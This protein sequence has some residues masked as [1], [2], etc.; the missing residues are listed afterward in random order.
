MT[1]ILHRA[2]NDP[3]PRELELL[4]D[5]T[6]H[7]AAGDSISSVLEAVATGFRAVLPFDRMEYS[8]VD[9]DDRTFVVHWVQA[10]GGPPALE[11]GTVCVLPDT[12]PPPNERKPFLIH[13]LPTY[14][15][16]MPADHSTRHLADAGYQAS[17]SCPLLL[18]DRVAAIVFFNTM[19][20]KT[21]NMRHLALVEL[22][23]GHLAIAAGR[24]ELTEELRASNE[25]LRHAQ[26]ART[27]FV[28]SVSHELRTPLTAV[29]GLARTM[30]D[31]LDSLSPAEVREFADVVSSQAQEVTALVDD[32]LVATR[33]EAGSLRVHIEPTDV[34]VAIA[35]TI[36]SLRGTTPPDVSGHSPPVAADPL[37]LRQIIRN[38]VTNAIR[39][40]G[41]DIRIRHRGTADDVIIE[42]SDDGPGVPDS[43]LPR[44][45]EAFG[46][47]NHVES[48]G[49]GLSVCRSLAVAMGGELVYERLAG[50]TVMR[51]RLPAA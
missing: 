40:G 27:E 28:A 48:V 35:E 37:R 23:A 45:F 47:T 32:L 41:A 42:V 49:L 36:E 4:L 46:L 17:I 1:A 15:R 24:A 43:R 12:L 9:E 19:Q 20:P 34:A 38:L 50:R 3:T 10:F 26:E 44:M 21:W 22:I 2:T 11:P 7:I 14:A 8:V 18:G 29:V 30:S 13:D 25:E 6:R 51:L 5:L 39:H 16:D 33:V 31:Q